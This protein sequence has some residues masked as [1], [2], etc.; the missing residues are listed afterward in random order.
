MAILP[1]KSFTYPVGRAMKLPI[2][3]LTVIVRSKIRSVVI[4]DGV[5]RGTYGP[6]E[7]ATFDLSTIKHSTTVTVVQTVVASLGAVP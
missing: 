2:L 4:H 7:L 3:R 1:D 5:R 6:F